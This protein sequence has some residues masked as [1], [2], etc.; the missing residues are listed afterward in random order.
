MKQLI[1]TL[2]SCLL[3][4][5]GFAQNIPTGANGPVGGLV[6]PI[7]PPAAISTTLA[8]KLNFTRVFVPTQPVGSSTAAFTLSG[9]QQV[10]VSTTYYNGMGQTLQTI[11]RQ[12]GG[13][14]AHKDIITVSD[15]RPSLRSNSYL[16]YTL[17]NAGLNAMNVQFRFSPFNEQNNFYNTFYPQEE[18]IAYASASVSFSNGTTVSKSYK[19]GK[20][21]VGNSRGTQTITTRND[22]TENI[23]IWTPGSGGSLIGSSTYAPG[24]LTLKKTTTA[25]G[26]SI[27]EYSNKDGQLVCK[28]QQL[29][30]NQLAYTCYVYNELGQI[31]SIITPKAYEAATTAL[32]TVSPTLLKNLCYTY[33]YDKYGQ[34]IEK[35]V[36]GRDFPDEMVYDS[37]KRTV[38]SRSALLNAQGKWA[39]SIYDSRGRVVMSG[40]YTSSNYRHELQQLVDNSSPAAGTLMHYLKNGFSGPY[41]AS[42]PNCDIQVYN[43]YDEYDQHSELAGR[44]YDNTYSA[45]F[46]TGSGMEIPEIRPKTNCYGLLTGKLVKVPGNPAGISAWIPTVYFYDQEGRVIQTQSRNAFNTTNWDVATSQFNFEGKPVLQIDQH[47][48]WAGTTKPSTKISTRYTY[49]AAN[50]ALQSTEQKIDGGSWYSLNSFNYDDLGRVMTKN[51][52]GIE[53]QQ[54]GYTLD[55]ALRSI[56][57]DY[58]QTGSG[59]DQTFGCIIATDYGFSQPMYDGGVSGLLWRGAGGALSPQRAYGYEYDDAGRLLGAEFRELTDPPGPNP[60]SWNKSMTDYTAGDIAYD[61]NGNMLS[62]SQ[63]GVAVQGG[64]M[65]PVTIDDLTYSYKPFSNQLDNIKDGVG[66]NYNKHDFLDTYTGTGDY[67]YDADGNLA[68]DKNKGISAISYNH[69]DLPLSIGTDKGS[70]KNTYDA[71]GNLVQKFIDPLAGNKQT[72]RY[73]GPFVY[74]NDSLQY[75]LHAEGRARWLVDSNKFKYDFFVKDHLGN[76]RTTITADQSTTRD[77]LAT[78]ELAS[79]LPEGQIWENL[80]ETRDERPAAISPNDTKAA[81]LNASEPTRR[82]GPALILQV[83]SGDKFALSTLAYVERNDK[84]PETVPAEDMLT[85]LLSVFGGSGNKIMGAPES[86][87]SGEIISNL[88]NSKNYVDAYTALQQDQADPD[89]TGAFL[90]YLVFDEKMMLVPEQSGFVQVQRTTD[91][92]QRLTVP[93]ITVARNGYLS[94]FMSNQQTATV[95]FDN[96]SL[97]HWKGR[98]LEENHYYPFGLAIYEPASNPVP[99][100][101]KY[102][103]KEMQDELGLELYDFHAR[104]YDPQIGRFWGIDPADQFPSGY[105]GMG[106]DPANGIDPTGMVVGGAVNMNSGRDGTYFNTNIEGSVDFYDWGSDVANPGGGGGSGGVQIINLPSQTLAYYYQDGVSGGGEEDPNSYIVDLRNNTTVQTDSKGGD[107]VDYVTTLFQPIPGGRTEIATA[108]LPVHTSYV[109]GFVAGTVVNRSPGSIVMGG[110]YTGKTEP[111]EDP[112]TALGPGAIRYAGARLVAFAER[113]MMVS[114]MIKSGE[115]GRD[116][117]SNFRFGVLTKETLDKPIILAR[118]YDDVSA[119]SRGRWFTNSFSSSKFMDR[120]GLALRPKWNAM[121]KTIYWEAPAGTTVYRGKAAMQFPWIGGKTQYY[122]PNS[123]SLIP[124]KN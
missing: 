74:R 61:V 121:T 46:L 117:A 114:A 73:E 50:S 6:A 98:L 95:W 10:R 63:R 13:S 52:G 77:Y 18:G 119:F 93:E 115:I 82:I 92:W 110:P 32:M 87:K 14:N 45:D 54:L 83:S 90:N 22:A 96:P 31:I 62:L 105:T 78:M 3:A 21:F 124:L 86:G 58:V 100:R 89:Q 64:I 102:Q 66:N 106:N 24:T 107:Q 79:A 7:T 42:I 120:M 36:P 8:G 103:G 44:N 5:P 17:H 75:V 111:T 49:D 70:I 48:S 81:A 76:V 43:Y 71:E 55:G 27:R 30:G 88:F 40:L 116:I 113:K 29:N 11:S 123:N 80:N 69:Q 91:Q 20:S 16:P 97:T 4:F 57:K 68:T 101:Y 99:N 109:Q 23:Y 47:Y 39:F 104:Q 72:W 53:Y 15:L 33:K 37:R 51:L 84:T 118:Y 60:L 38:L 85:S 41:P 94:V 19:A 67:T 122:I 35:G 59:S 9:P 65:Q 26:A 12:A 25:D 28:V 108:E 112:F 34:L 1:I 56:N 2:L